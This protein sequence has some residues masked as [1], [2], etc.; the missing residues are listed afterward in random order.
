[1]VSSPQIV[2][3]TAGIR[4]FQDQMFLIFS[5]FS[6]CLTASG[7][8]DLGLGKNYQRPWLRRMSAREHGGIMLSMLFCRLQVLALQGREPSTPPS[9]TDPDPRPSAPE[10]AVQ[11]PVLGREDADGDLGHNDYVLVE[12]EGFY[13]KETPR[14]TK[15]GWAGVVQG[16]YSFTKRG[17]EKRSSWSRRSLCVS[18]RLIC[19]GPDIGNP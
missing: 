15:G 2:V 5:K 12:D 8:R 11:Q 18:L 3:R 9:L 19:R 17:R 6:G 1:M 10:A 13:G 14:V 4:V 16:L 7:A